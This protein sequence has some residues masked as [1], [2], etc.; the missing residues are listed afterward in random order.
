M[1]R[2]LD[3]M[4]RI[5]GTSQ[6]VNG[7][8]ILRHLSYIEATSSPVGVLT[9]EWVGQCVFDTVSLTFWRAAGLTNTSWV[10]FADPAQ[11]TPQGG[12]VLAG[13][14]LTVTAALHNN[15]IIGLDQLA[16]SVCTLPAATGSGAKFKFIVWILATSVS[17]KIQVANASDFMIGSIAGVSDDPATVKG[18]IAANSGT[19]G[20]NSDTIT[21]NRSTTGSVSKGEY[22]EAVDISANT[23]L[24]SGLITQ[25][26]TE[27]TP[28]TAAV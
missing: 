28:F 10:V 23:W 4:T 27:A 14:A 11:T 7:A 6:W 18:W 5:V 3:V 20:T 13:S 1:L 26:G 16:G 21:L 25:T 8:S 12:L 24:V 17:H 22:V 2:P 15:R 9:P 19:V